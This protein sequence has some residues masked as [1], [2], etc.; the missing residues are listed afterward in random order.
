L[1]PAKNPLSALEQVVLEQAIVSS[2]PF[3]LTDIPTFSWGSGSTVLLVHGWGGYGL[4][5]SEFVKPLL[6]AGFRVLAFDAPAHGRAAGVQT[7]GLEMA[8]VI[9]TV[10]LH[11]G[12]ITG[13][14]AH[15]LGATSTTLALSEGLQTDRVVY[16]GAIC[17]LLNAAGLF[18]RLSRL[19][20]EV[21]AAFQASFEAQFGQDIWHRFAAEQTA[22]HLSIPALLFHDRNDREVSV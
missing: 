3:G 19:S 13:V 18:A 6:N 21:E 15:S 17:W 12:P 11:Q 20:T 10:A 5:L 22:R 8:Q 1:T 4:Q 9:A 7:N 14:I 2:I 16:L